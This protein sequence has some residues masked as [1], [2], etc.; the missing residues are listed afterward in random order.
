MC[1]EIIVQYLL[2]QHTN[3][4]HANHTSVLQLQRKIDGVQLHVLHAYSALKENPIHAV[5]QYIRVQ[6]EE[7]KNGRAKQEIL[8]GSEDLKCSNLRTSRNLC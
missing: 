2:Y 6:T 4:V 3:R 1:M 7:I 5:K 8:M